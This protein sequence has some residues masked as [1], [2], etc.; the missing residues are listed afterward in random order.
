M[1]RYIFLF[2]CLLQV[3]LTFAQ[4]NNGQPNFL[5]G[6]TPNEKTHDFGRILEKDGKV[7]TTFIFTNRT[8]KVVSIS[9]VN[10]WCGC[11]VPK[12]TKKGIRPGETAKIQVDFDPDHKSGNFVKQVVLLLNDGKEYARVWI[13]ANVVPFLHPVKEDHPYDY[14]E[15]L[16]MS[17][18]ILP[19]PDLD[20]GQSHSYELKLA[21][22]TDKPMTV[23]FRRMPNNTV[24]KMPEKITLKARERTSIRV[25][26]T[27]FRKHKVSRSIKVI[28]IV[29]G[30][31][32]KPLKVRWNAGNNKFRL[33]N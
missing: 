8:Q 10:T 6:F 22:D 14:G 28:P 5:K 1:K 18:Q 30:K 23:E 20:P 13:K 31:E 2:I 24:L 33:L 15:G 26:Y 9:E 7:S 25:S 27:Y 17:Q 29:N 12:Y 16:Y 32:C 11:V 3:S 19:F 21:N 4:A